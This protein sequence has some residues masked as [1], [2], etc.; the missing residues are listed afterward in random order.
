MS[1]DS[2]DR[3]Y[4]TCLE[5]QKSITHVFK[6]SSP[7]PSLRAILITRKKANLILWIGLPTRDVVFVRRGR[8]GGGMRKSGLRRYKR[9]RLLKGDGGEKKVEAHSDGEERSVFG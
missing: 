4:D 6:G 5:H 7:A 1:R 2:T 3:D 8:Q 9:I